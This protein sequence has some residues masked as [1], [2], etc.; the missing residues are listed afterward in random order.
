VRTHI[1]VC[2]GDAP[3]L[4]RLGGYACVLTVETSHDTDRV[5]DV[6]TRVGILVHAVAFRSSEPLGKTDLHEEW[7]RSPIALFAPEM[8]G[9]QDVVHRLDQ[10]RRL[11]IRVFLPVDRPENLTSLRVLAS[12]GVACAAELGGRTVDWD[13]FAD[14]ATYAL[15]GLTPH[16]TIEPFQALARD[17]RSTGRTTLRSVSFEDPERFVHAD[18][19]GRLAFNGREL[20]SGQFFADDL[21]AIDHLV[22]LPGYRARVDAWRTVFMEMNPCSSCPGWRIC[23]SI[24]NDGLAENPGCRVCTEEIMDVI[25]KHAALPKGGELVW[26]V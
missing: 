7:G 5:I 9:F 2:P 15:L 10:F 17:Y 26:Q 23:G 22:D 25:E 8:G 24:L 6:A 16:G 11:N 13:A 14:L 21:D 3:Y 19:A 12:L 18:S 1:L 20:R 4:D